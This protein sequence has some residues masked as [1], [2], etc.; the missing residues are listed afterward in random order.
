MFVSLLFYLCGGYRPNYNDFDKTQFN[1]NSI[2]LSENLFYFGLLPPILFNSGFHLRRN[3]FVRNIK[4]IFLLA[5]VGTLISTF[6]IAYVLKYLYDNHFEVLFDSP[7]I[8]IEWME[9]VVFASLLSS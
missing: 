5:I 6:V 4:P 2:H 7:S 8:K 3:L 9:F 1:V